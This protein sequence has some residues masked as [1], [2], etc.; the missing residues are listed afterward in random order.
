MNEPTIVEQLEAANLNG[1]KLTADLDA[2]NALLAETNGKL[3]LALA[4]NATLADAINKAKTDAEAV[5]AF[6]DS[7]TAALE[8]ANAEAATTKAALEAA[9]AKLSLK[10]F[11]DISGREP[12]NGGD[13]ADAGTSLSEQLSAIKDPVEKS[14][15]MTKHYTALMAETKTRKGN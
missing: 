9:N 13:G 11:A 4:E 14:R 5:K 8:A 1:A 15:F 7:Q 6:A 2:A 12:I 3:Q 10:A